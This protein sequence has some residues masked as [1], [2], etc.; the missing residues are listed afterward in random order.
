MNYK[1]RKTQEWYENSYKE[2]GINAQRLYPNEELLRFLGREYFSN[3]KY[4]DRS[5][6]RVLEIGCGS[7]ANLWMV[8][9]EGFDAYGL[10]LSNSALSLGRKVLEHWSVDANLVNSSMTN[11]PFEDEFFDVIFDVFSS[12]CLEDE[13]FSQCLDEV[14]RCLKKGGKFFSYS[15]SV[16]SDAYKKYEPARKIDKWTLDGIKN[17]SMSYCG[18]NYPF[19]FISPEY[20]RSQ[21]EKRQLDVEY[22]ELVGRTY[23]FQQ[24]YFEFVTIVGKKKTT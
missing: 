21:L 24:E 14:E 5:S 2:K 13:G 11:I 22:M 18:Q 6:I 12:Y 16:E 4:K 19:R 8:S 23:S 7:C 1:N 15:P 10:D 17:T 20:Y 3:V 9:K